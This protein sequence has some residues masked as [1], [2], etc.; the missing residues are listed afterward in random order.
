VTLACIGSCADEAAE[1]LTAH[2][3]GVSPSTVKTFVMR[4]YEK[5]EVGRGLTA[6]AL[7]SNVGGATLKHVG[8]A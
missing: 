1:H 5:V 8:S 2:E 6:S 3:L 7:R 4:M